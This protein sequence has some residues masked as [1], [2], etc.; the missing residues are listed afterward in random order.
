MLSKLS[1]GSA[2]NGIY[3]IPIIPFLRG[4]RG[5]PGVNGHPIVG[6]YLL[7]IYDL[8]IGILRVPANVMRSNVF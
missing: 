4:S 1:E 2:L 7:N 3:V 6:K 8:Y 5:L